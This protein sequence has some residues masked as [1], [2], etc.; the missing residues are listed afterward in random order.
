MVYFIS[1]FERITREKLKYLSAKANALLELD[2]NRD[3]SMHLTSDDLY[4][5]LYLPI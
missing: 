4:S 1:H 2:S 5:P 3:I